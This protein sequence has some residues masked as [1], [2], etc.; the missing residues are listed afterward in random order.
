M[1]KERIFK[2]N[3]LKSNLI[4]MTITKNKKNFDNEL[5]FFLKNNLL[6]NIFSG[7]ENI[8]GVSNNRIYSIKDNY[9]K[10]IEYLMLKTGFINDYLIDFRNIFINLLNN[11]ELN[12]ENIKK[13]IY[14][15][16][17][18]E[19]N[20]SIKNDINKSELINEEKLN[21]T[22][23]KFFKLLEDNQIKS[24]GE[25]TKEIYNKLKNEFNRSIC[26]DINKLKLNNEDIEKEIYNKLDEIDINFKKLL[27]D[28]QIK[29]DENTKNITKKMDYLLTNKNNNKNNN[30]ENKFKVQLL[31]IF[32]I[33]IIYLL[34]INT[35]LLFIDYFQI[36]NKNNFLQISK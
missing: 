24:Y 5:L 28:Y 6:Y 26:N 15:K 13:E 31:I 7:N 10:Y 23:T 29:N 11:L 14:N 20:I 18:N 33:I 9:P 21:Q 35:K 36:D 3:F 4:S 17:K 19:L 32:F 1:N 22:Y 30:I 25:I 27:E 8:L 34:I 2:N 12:N 16:L